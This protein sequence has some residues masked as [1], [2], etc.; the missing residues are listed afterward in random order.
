VETAPVERNIPQ[1]CSAMIGTSTAI[2]GLWS[3]TAAAEQK[4]DVALHRA[5]P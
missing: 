3:V 2:G 4:A 5:K 1:N